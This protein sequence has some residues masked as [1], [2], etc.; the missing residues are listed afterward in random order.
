MLAKQTNCTEIYRVLFIPVPVDT[1]TIITLLGRYVSVP[2]PCQQRH[3][4]EARRQAPHIVLGREKGNECRPVQLEVRCQLAFNINLRHRSCPRLRATHLGQ[5][6]ILQKTVY[7]RGK[8][9]PIVVQGKTIGT[10][11]LT[12]LCATV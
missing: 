5:H 10:C 1:G 9:Q 12:A 7:P 4:A 11:Y 2:E 8:N 3:N 6:R